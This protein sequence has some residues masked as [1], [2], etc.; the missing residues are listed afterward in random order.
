MKIYV[1]K[2]WNIY[3]CHLFN[4]TNILNLDVLGDLSDFKKLA[5]FH[6]N[7]TIFFLKKS[8]EF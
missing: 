8:K 3:D 2:F 5:Y 7:Y 1:L 4:V 6:E